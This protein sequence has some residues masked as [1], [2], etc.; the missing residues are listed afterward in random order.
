MNLQKI[1]DICNNY[2]NVV[3]SGHIHPDGD[4]V[5]ACYA[6]AAI[7]HKKGIEAKVA[8]DDIPDTYSYLEGSSYLLKTIKKDID[9]FISLD[10]GDKE[11]LGN[12]SN[13]FDNAQV[14]INI[15]HHI[16]NTKFAKYNHVLDV[17]STCEIIY[18]LIDD[19]SILDKNIC[20]ALYTG[21]IFDTGAFKHSNTTKRTH[22]IAGELI[23][24]DIDFTEMTNRVFYYR[25]YNALKI[26]SVAINNAKL[27]SE[28]EIIVSTL[29]I[30]E[31]KQN[32]CYKKDT[33][34]IIQMLNEVI[35]TQCA[36]L[37][38]QITDN[39]YKVSLRSK[40]KV[41]VCK[42]AK[43]FSGGGHI[44]ASGCTVSGT[45]K[46]VEEIIVNE[47]VKQL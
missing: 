34:G 36:V 30:E 45:I 5:G 3:I 35:G 7:L 15:D 24:Y 23:K 27:Y 9:V 13:M 26:L 14:T 32:N 21:I 31:L 19:Y 38:T 4:C 18:E 47:I 10:C 16:S 6:L 11:R 25:S 2:N 37:I 40:N 12:Y 29:T 46:E 41:D 28:N 43:K 22:E 39:D 17:S 44:K 33:D 42:V 8:L 20:E 1:V